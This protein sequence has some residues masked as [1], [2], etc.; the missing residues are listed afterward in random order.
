M[1][2]VSIDKISYTHRSL[3]LFNGDFNVYNVTV[4]IKHPHDNKR[5]EWRSN[6]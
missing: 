1:E 3:L 4:K 2:Y 5:S 6:N